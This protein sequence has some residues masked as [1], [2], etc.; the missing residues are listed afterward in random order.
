MP[1][2]PPQWHYGRPNN[3]MLSQQPLAAWFAN[4]NSCVLSQHFALRL[5][6]ASE[7]KHANLI[8]DVVPSTSVK[9]PCRR[10]YG[11]KCKNKDK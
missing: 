2:L 9:H 1:T 10:A 6:Q 5:R 4:R 8:S 7:G 3:C 11:L